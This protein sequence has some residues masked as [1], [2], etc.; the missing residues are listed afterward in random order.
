M[1]IRES[2]IEAVELYKKA[3]SLN[4][5]FIMISF[6][7]S[8]SSIASLSESIFK[9]KGFILD[10]VDFYQHYIAEIIIYYAGFVGLSY[11][12]NQV[13]SAVILSIAVSLGMKMFILDQL[14]FAEVMRDKYNFEVKPK[15]NLFRIQA[16]AYSVFVWLSFGLSEDNVTLISSIILLMSYPIFVSLIHWILVNFDKNKTLSLSNVSYCKVYYV[17]LAAIFLMLGVL[18]AINSGISKVA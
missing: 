8:V 15:I 16:V 7:L 3:G 14:K 9:W 12:Q 18:G 11:T 6:F 13:H 2:F 10:A 4:R 17:Y 1:N 5:I